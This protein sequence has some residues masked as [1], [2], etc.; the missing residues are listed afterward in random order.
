MTRPLTIAEIGNI[1]E[2]H[3]A[4]FAAVAQRDAIH[5][6]DVA[7]AVSQMAINPAVARTVVAT[8]TGK[9]LE[10]VA[11]G[12][13]TWITAALIIRDT[14]SAHPKRAIGEAFYRALAPGFGSEA[15]SVQ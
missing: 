8:A 9:R 7:R 15:G 1:I 10:E 12:F 3:P 4:A 6:D 2:Q 13:G 5:P 14:I 11:H